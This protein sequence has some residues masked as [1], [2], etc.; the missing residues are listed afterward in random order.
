M[1]KEDIKRILIINLGGIGDTLLSTPALRALRKR[2]PDVQISLLIIPRVF[3]LAKDLSFI[4]EVFIFYTD[5]RIGYFFKNLNTLLFLRKKHFD[6]AINMRTLVTKSGALK[7]RL[8]LD[9]INPKIKAGRDTQG[10]GSFFDIKIPET[11]KA[12]KYEM[13]YDIEIV[14]ALGARV[15][16]KAIDF[17]IK[18]SNFKK[19]NQILET[20]GIAESDVLIGIYPGGKKSHRWQIENF[21]KVIDEI[22]LKI[23]SKFIITGSNDESSLAKKL[24]QINNTNVINLVGKL[25]LKELGAVIKVCE[26]YIANDSG[27]MHIAAILGTPLI[28]IFGPGE[29]DRFDPRHISNRAVVFYRKVECAPCFRTNCK[30]LRCLKSIYPEEVVEA[31]LKLLEIKN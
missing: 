2:Y 18:E 16:D 5:Y 12:D 27:P 25:S 8:L 21:S 28:A 29:I 3:K 13:D 30:S 4:D 1:L 9:I 26:L 17:E 22:E 6:L 20:E 11:V 31:A 7:I 10:R 23:P 19:I 15:L 14:E 24:V